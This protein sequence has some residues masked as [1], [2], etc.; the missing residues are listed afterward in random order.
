MGGL[1]NQLFQIATTIALAIKNN[2][3]TCFD[4][5]N[6]RIGLQGKNASNYKSNVYRKLNNGIINN[7]SNIYNETGFHYSKIPYKESLKIVGYFQSEKYFIDYRDE[8]LNLF[9]PNE[10]II[11]YINS[12]Y[13]D[14]LTKKTCSLHVRRGDYLNFSDNHPPLQLKYYQDAIK[15]FD[16]DTLFLVFSDDINWCKTVFIGNNFIFIE[17]EEDYIDL[18]IMSLCKNNIIANSSFSWWGSWLNKNK[19]KKIIAPSKWFGEKLSDLKT[20]DVYTTKMIKL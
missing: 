5:D 17:N 8:I 18:Y 12:K 3:E 7:I 9:E 6:H 10:N 19:D 2:D 11:T 15:N 20:E 13:G 1:G 16:S 4:I 14:I